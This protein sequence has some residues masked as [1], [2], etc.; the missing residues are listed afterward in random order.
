[1]ETGCGLSKKEMT[2]L[3]KN[4]SL[5]IYWALEQAIKNNSNEWQEGAAVFRA[6]SP[7]EL[8]PP[9]SAPEQVGR[10]QVAWPLCD[11]R[12]CCC[13]L[14]R[15]YGGYPQQW[16]KD[17]CASSRD[18]RDAT[19]SP[20]EGLLSGNYKGKSVAAGILLVTPAL[21][22]QRLTQGAGVGLSVCCEE[23]VPGHPELEWDL[24]PKPSKTQKKQ[25]NK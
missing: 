7:C 15:E 12:T 23:W 14:Y 4:P 10:D 3:K 2:L 25:E 19:S 9:V 1:M 20:G 16:L 6:N 5:N 21:P 24:S 22:L 17:H 11:V 8:S 13:Q 18:C